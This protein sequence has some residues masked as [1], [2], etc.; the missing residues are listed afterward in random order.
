M[1]RKQDIL[2]RKRMR[3]KSRKKIPPSI[4]RCHLIVHI[5][6]DT[7][8]HRFNSKNLSIHLLNME[9]LQFF[10]TKMTET[11]S[12]TA[13]TLGCVRRSGSYSPAEDAAVTGAYIHI[14]MEPVTGAKQKQFRTARASGKDADEKTQQTLPLGHWIPFLRFAT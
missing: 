7:P 4:H 11:T 2:Y 12:N 13:E 8:R 14:R 1:E 9:F 3:E 6:M 5:V 10:S